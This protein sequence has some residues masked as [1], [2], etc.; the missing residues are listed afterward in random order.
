M[1]RNV[2]VENDFHYHPVQMYH[3]QEDN[4]EPA[5]SYTATASS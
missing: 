5:G 2:T 1:L 4:T 3:Y